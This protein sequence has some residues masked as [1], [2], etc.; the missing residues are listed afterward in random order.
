MISKLTSV[1]ELPWLTK[2]EDERSGCGIAV[3][4]VHFV[5]DVCLN[6]VRAQHYMPKRVRHVQFEAAQKALTVAVIGRRVAHRKFV[7]LATFLHEHHCQ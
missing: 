4:V 3:V 5:V 7:V 2:P 1:L 6:L